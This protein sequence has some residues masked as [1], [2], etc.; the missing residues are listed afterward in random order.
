MKVGSFIRTT[1]FSVNNK[2]YDLQM[3][4]YYEIKGDLLHIVNRDGSRETIKI[5]GDLINTLNQCAATAAEME[6]YARAAETE[7]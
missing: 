4:M 5:E 1:I 6:E 3:I 7:C 2:K